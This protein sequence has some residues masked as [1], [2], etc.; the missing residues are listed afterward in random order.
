MFKT[1]LKIESNWIRDKIVFSLCGAL[2]LKSEKV[3]K[4]LGQKKKVF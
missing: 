4:G 3:R 2:H 1:K